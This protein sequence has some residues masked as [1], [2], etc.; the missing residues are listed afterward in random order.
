MNLSSEIIEVKSFPNSRKMLPLLEPY[1]SIKYIL[2]AFSWSLGTDN[3]NSFSMRALARPF[4]M[5]GKQKIEIK[6]INATNLS[7]QQYRVKFF[8]PFNHKL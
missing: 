5:L 6:S 4:A 3:L 7:K 2:T 8:N 1:L